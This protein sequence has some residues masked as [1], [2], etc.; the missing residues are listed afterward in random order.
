MRTLLP[1]FI[2]LVAGSAFSQSKHEDKAIVYVYSLATTPTSGQV[3]KPVFLDDKE[4]ADI[5][6]EHFFIVLVRPGRHAFHLRVKKF[7]GVE[8]D[9]VAGET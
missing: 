3:K 7:G 2:L 8:K 9:F 4:L 1:L 5:R 6:P